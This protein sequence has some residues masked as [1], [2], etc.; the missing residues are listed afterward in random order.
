[1]AKV[2][3]IIPVYNVENYLKECLDS[4]INQTMKEL[5]IICVDDGSTD[6]SK[7]ILDQYASKDSRI[8]VIHKK[9][10]GYGKAI[11]VGVRAASSDYLGIVE[12]DDKIAPEMYEDLYEIAKN[13]RVDV[14]KADHYEFYANPEGFYITEYIPL[15]QKQEEIHLY[16]KILNIREN[17]EV[18]KFAK[19]TWSGIYRMEFLRGNHI[20]HNETPGASYQDNGFW[21]QTMAKSKS[22]YF[23]RKA[24]YYYRIDNPNSSVVSTTKVMAVNNEYD[25]ID[26]ILCEMG[27]EGD[28]FRKWSRYFRLWGNVGVISQLA[29]E[30]KEE[31]ARVTKQEYIQGLQLGEIDADLYEGYL[32]ERLFDI[33]ADVRRFVRKDWS[34]RQKIERVTKNYSMVI[35]YGAGQ[36]GK[37]VQGMLKEGRVNTKIKYFAVSDKNGELTEVKGIPVREIR[38]LEMYRKK[39]LV[40]ISVGKA[41]ADDV[42][43]MLQKYGFE[44]WIFYKDMM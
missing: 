42:K 41:Y 31:L 20:L 6:H 12:S 4:V 11:N 23:V 15:T 17:M 36:I 38:E 25:F 24:Y 16:E 34:R 1:M 2:S 32:K 8:Q 39:A 5:E 9:N 35:L 44:H 30:Y 22:I 28:V 29:D 21:F 7:D 13:H 27:R 14:V 18:M 33:L 19:Y 10:E 43:G 3:V 26:E 37:M 40:I